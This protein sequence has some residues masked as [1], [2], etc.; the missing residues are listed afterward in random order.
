[1]GLMR[2]FETV[3]ATAYVEAAWVLI[4]TSHKF[5]GAGA[6]VGPTNEGFEWKVT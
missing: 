1:M 2:R 4:Q 3:G 6:G 5:A